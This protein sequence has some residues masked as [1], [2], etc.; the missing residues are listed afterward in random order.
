VRY[1]TLRSQMLVVHPDGEHEWRWVDLVIDT[2]NSCIGVQLV[3]DGPLRG[4]LILVPEASIWQA[5]E[6]GV[7]S[8][9]LIIKA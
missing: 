9:K 7:E 1:K 5:K 4:T 8:E 2:E 3:G 6:S